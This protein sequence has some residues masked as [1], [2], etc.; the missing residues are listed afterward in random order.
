MVV[1]FRVSLIKEKFQE[2]VQ[3]KEEEDRQGFNFGLKKDMIQ[4]TCNQSFLFLKENE[5]VYTSGV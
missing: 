5:R 4:E 1:G 3:M 2:I